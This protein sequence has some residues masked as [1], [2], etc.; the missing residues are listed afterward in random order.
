MQGCCFR[1][2]DCSSQ[3]YIATIA[4]QGTEVYL[5]A[6][7]EKCKTTLRYLLDNILTTLFDVT[8]PKA[9]GVGARVH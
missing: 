4:H 9:T 8:M 3:V 5:F 7:C 2:P 1:C 6:K